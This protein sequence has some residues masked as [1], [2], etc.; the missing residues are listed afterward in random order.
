MLKRESDGG[1]EGQKYVQQNK[2]Q[3][4]NSD[5]DGQSHIYTE[6]EV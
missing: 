5:A 6:A 3:T 1:L 4:D 2:I